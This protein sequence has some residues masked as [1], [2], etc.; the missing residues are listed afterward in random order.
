M[1]HW[2]FG[3]L[4]AYIVLGL[5]SVRWRKAGRVAALLTVGVLAYAFHSYGAL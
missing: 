5:S 3:L 2:G 1:S 4:A